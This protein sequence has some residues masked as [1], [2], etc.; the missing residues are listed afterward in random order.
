[1]ALP[2]LT[3][4]DPHNLA[5]DMSLAMSPVLTAD[6][7]KSFEFDRSSGRPATASS[8]G[9]NDD[10]MSRTYSSQQA[11]T[12]LFP[13]AASTCW[14]AHAHTSNA[15]D[16]SRARIELTMP[17][18]RPATPSTGRPSTGRQHNNTL[19]TTTSSPSRGPSPGRDASLRQEVRSQ[20]D[21]LSQV[22]IPPSIHISARIAPLTRSR[23]NS[24]SSSA[25]R[26][27]RHCLMLCDRRVPVA[28]SIRKTMLRV[29]M[30]PCLRQRLHTGPTPTIMRAKS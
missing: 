28:L 9:Y 25:P 22:H 17:A 18:A 13:R 20:I 1:M 27:P 7:D 3:L 11:Q 2:T 19:S 12:C 15:R 6:S 8:I 21:P 14:H 5:A 30:S 24:K 23:D 4:T 16:R 10:G 26:V 29:S